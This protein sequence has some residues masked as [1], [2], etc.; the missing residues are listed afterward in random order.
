MKNGD[1]LFVASL[2][3]LAFLVIFFGVAAVLALI[4]KWAWSLVLVPIF[5]LPPITFWQAIAI[6]L[7][8]NLF[9]RPGWSVTRSK[10]DENQRR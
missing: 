5:H 6:T 4:L 8:L 1:V 10:Q 3:I 7:I 9:I 2:S